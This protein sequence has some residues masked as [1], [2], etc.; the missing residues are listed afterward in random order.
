MLWC[1]QDNCIKREARC[2]GEGWEWVGWYILRDWAREPYAGR[3]PW[4]SFLWRTLQ[5]VRRS[6]PLE[7][8]GATSDS[9]SMFFLLAAGDLWAG[10]CAI[11]EC[12]ER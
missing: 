5:R 9:P 11:E 8:E 7:E 10:F 6:G 1:G 3:R 2:R 12:D 4:A